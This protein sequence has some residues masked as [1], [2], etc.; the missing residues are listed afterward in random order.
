MGH[1]LYLL[2]KGPLAVCFNFLVLTIL[3]NP[4]NSFKQQHHLAVYV[5]LQVICQYD[6]SQQRHSNRA[7]FN[8][9]QSYLP[10]HRGQYET[11]ISCKRRLQSDKGGRARGD[12]LGI[13]EAPSQICR[14]CRLHT[15]HDTA[16]EG[17]FF[18]TNITTNKYQ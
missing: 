9:C 17:Y 8:E 3:C 10:R 11:T 7:Y 12:L 6:P 1:F 2:D 4:S 15:Q 13:H 14:A 5:H 16:L 18:R